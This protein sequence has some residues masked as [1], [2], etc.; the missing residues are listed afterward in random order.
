[1]SLAGSRNADPGLGVRDPMN[2]DCQLQSSA[3]GGDNP[4]MAKDSEREDDSSIALQSAPGPFS[5]GSMV[6]VTLGNPR[7]KF[8]GMI[9]GAGA[10]R[11]QHERH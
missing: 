1:M 9:S 11:A 8:W 4:F 3:R 10:G 7:D 6:V 2:R 5:H